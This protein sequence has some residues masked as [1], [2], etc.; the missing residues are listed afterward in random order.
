MK[1]REQQK[2]KRGP[3]TLVWSAPAV[4]R[5]VVKGESGAPL[6][7]WDTFNAESLTKMR[8]ASQ[9]LR[10]MGEQL[11]V[12]YKPLPLPA[13]CDDVAAS[14]HLTA[15]GQV[16]LAALTETPGIHRLAEDLYDR[17]GPR[18][19]VYVD[20]PDVRIVLALPNGTFT[21]YAG[22]VHGWHGAVDLCQCGTCYEWY[23]VAQCGSWHCQASECPYSGNEAL[24]EQYAS[25]IPA[26]VWER[27]S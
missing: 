3:L 4:R 12:R 16:L 19:H 20:D 14:L 18:R 17:I 5:A 21:G 9:W 2:I 26:D 15:S 8:H 27:A 23:F 10:V 7:V 22:P 1:R 13:R 24:L 6:Q 11:D 25:C